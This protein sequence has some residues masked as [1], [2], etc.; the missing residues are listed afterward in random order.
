[1]KGEE[2]TLV[3]NLQLFLTIEQHKSVQE[4]GN[5]LHFWL[6]TEICTKN[7]N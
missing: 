5:W 4:R 7:Q 2:R 6:D 1:M 3:T